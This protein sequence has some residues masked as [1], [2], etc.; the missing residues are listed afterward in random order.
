[1][2]EKAKKKGDQNPTWQEPILFQLWILFNLGLAVFYKENAKG[3]TISSGVSGDGIPNSEKNL[4]E[5]VL[6]TS[7]S[8][9][10]GSVIISVDREKK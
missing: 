9:V 1:M 2:K 6:Q 3:L 8:R 4:L 10:L 5:E 7:E